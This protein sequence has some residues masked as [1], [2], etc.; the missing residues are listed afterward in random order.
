MDR[1]C[2]Q[3]THPETSG[4]P[5]R[6]RQLATWNPLTLPQPPTTMTFHALQGLGARDIPALT[7]AGAGALDLWARPLGWSLFLGPSL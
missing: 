5:S 4:Q 1:C 7:G 3:S 6:H 2:A